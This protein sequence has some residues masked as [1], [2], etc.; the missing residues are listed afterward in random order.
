MVKERLD[1]LL[2]ARGLFSSRQKARSAILAGEVL[3]N[4]TKIDKPGIKI[5][6]EVNI[7]LKRKSPYV[8]RGGEKLAGALKEFDC[9]VNGKIALDAGA[10]TGGFTDCL[11][12]SGA[13]KVYSVDVGY[14]QLAWKLRQD[15]RVVVIERKNIRYFQKAD[16]EDLPDLVTLDLS[17]ISL[18]KVLEVVDR[19]LGPRGEVIALIK[20]QF[21]AG[22]EKVA[23]GGVIKDSRV[24]R[25]VIRKVIE[26]AEEI[27]F[28]IRG[29]TVSPLKGP[30][31]NIEYFIYLTRSQKGMTDITGRIEEMVS[32]AHRGV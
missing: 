9:P 15:P 25:E 32:R 27:G 4:G 10:S 29:L 14:G 1:N 23:R 26:K 11:L 20:P 24:H 13:K 6:S 5:D 16:L 19:L 2:F 30:A 7:E 12:Q 31:G 28:Q 22:R 3:V 21:E 8:S 18:S 17:F